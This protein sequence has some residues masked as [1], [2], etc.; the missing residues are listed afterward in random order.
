MFK[1]LLMDYEISQFGWGVYKVAHIFHDTVWKILS[2][3]FWAVSFYEFYEFDICRPWKC[4]TLLRRY[5]FIYWLY[6]H[7]MMTINLKYL[8]NEKR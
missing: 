5:R 2:W 6:L 7:G 3:Q 4:F 1:I 8:E